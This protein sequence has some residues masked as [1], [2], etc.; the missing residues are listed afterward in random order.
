[1]TPSTTGHSTVLN[2]F[3]QDCE[4]KVSLHY[5]DHRIFLMYILNEVRQEIVLKLIFHYID[6]I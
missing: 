2:D 6:N 3:F 5:S 4:Q 1:M